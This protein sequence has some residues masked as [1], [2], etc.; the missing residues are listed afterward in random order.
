MKERIRAQRAPR[1]KASRPK[2]PPVAAPKRAVAAKRRP[3]GYE[4]RV[5]ANLSP[6]LA[7]AAKEMAQDRALA[8]SD[9]HRLRRLATTDAARMF[10]AGLGAAD[11]VR[12][13]SRMP[14]EPGATLDFSLDSIRAG[15]SMLRTGGSRPPVAK[16]A[17][18]RQGPA[19]AEVITGTGPGEGGRSS[20]DVNR[21][22]ETF[23]T[24]TLELA[25][26][27]HIPFAEAAR[28]IADSN[29]RAASL[30]ADLQIVP[31]HPQRSARLEQAAPAARGALVFVA[32]NTNLP[33]ID[34]MSAWGGQLTRRLRGELGD[35]N[36]D[37]TWNPS[38]TYALDT[39]RA[40]VQ[41]VESRLA[42][43]QIG[44]LVIDVE[45]HGGHGEVSGLGQNLG[46]SIVGLG[47]IP[48]LD[49]F[50]RAHNVHLVFVE[51]ACSMGL[52]A[53]A[54]SANAFRTLA[55]RA[56]A[57]GAPDVHEQL[58]A[59][60]VLINFNADVSDLLEVVDEVLDHEADASLIPAMFAHTGK[61]L[62][63]HIPDGG[64]T[65]YGLVGVPEALKTLLA[66]L[67]LDIVYRSGRMG[68]PR[69][70]AN[71]FRPPGFDDRAF[72]TAFLERGRT[73]VEQAADVTNRLLESVDH[74][75]NQPRTSATS[76]TPGTPATR[77]PAR[78]HG[79]AH[80]RH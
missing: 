48:T 63:E 53:T 65:I 6:V 27:E 25:E 22:Q 77:P 32:Y 34:M 78:R 57:A 12:A 10:V 16:R 42:A 7:R 26:S 21:P 64:S 5:G 9:L 15:A 50:A 3:A 46:H 56:G 74:V 2:A 72:L 68:P 40:W 60:G 18:Q 76:A 71:E 31:F 73:A 23:L 17:L 80:H 37:I 67:W 54:A 47:D 62:L 30:S 79:A 69:A 20:P 29:R 52:A 19:P 1:E 51:D 35:E 39:I 36:V 58:E 43:G 59:A 70:F 45:G 13:L 66:Y 8:R 33:S 14:L 55:A 61:S 24:S 41:R 38:H 44:E 75:L 28:R 49:Q 11:N 4:F